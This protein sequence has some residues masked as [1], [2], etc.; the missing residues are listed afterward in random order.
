MRKKLAKKALHVIKSGW[1]IEGKEKEKFEKKFA[2]YCGVKHAIGVGNGLDA[3]SLIIQGYKVLGTFS[4]QDEIIVPANTYIASILAISQNNLKPILVEPDDATYLINTKKI[5]KL[6]T[7]KTKAIMPVHLYG[8][9]CD[10]KPI[11]K[12]AKKYGLKIIEDAAQAHGAYYKKKKAG[13]LGDAAGFSFYPGKTL[14]ALGDAGI[15]TTND[16][17]LAQIVSSLANY[18]STQ[19]YI[20]PYRGRNSRLDEIQAAFL[21]LK[22]KHL[23]KEIE[24]RKHIAKLYKKH[25]KNK[26][27]KLPEIKTDSSW[28]LFVIRTPYRKELQSYL[29]AHKIETMI[30]YPIPPHKQ[31]AYSNYGDLSLPV[32][33]KLAQEVLSLP[34]NSLLTKQE[35]AYIIQTINDFEVK[36]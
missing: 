12:L 14:G 10:M 31:K 27:I 15:I 8:Q 18:G 13:G 36:R 6:L 2:S 29:K 4:D 30:H 17:A 1:F 26:Y 16:T 3:L 21:S 7:P 25:I 24:K 22:L 33:E 23:N 11:R 34:I 5:E 35:V 19:K 32:T 9:T 20:H 28:H